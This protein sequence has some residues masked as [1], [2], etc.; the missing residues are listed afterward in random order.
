MDWKR[1]LVVYLLLGILGGLIVWGIVASTTSSTPAPTASA[2]SLTTA[3]IAKKKTVSEPKKELA[4]AC[5]PGQLCCYESTTNWFNCFTGRG[6][7]DVFNLAMLGLVSSGPRTIGPLTLAQTSEP[8]QAPQFTSAGFSAQSVVFDPTQCVWTFTGLTGTL[9]I[10]NFG[11]SDLGMACSGASLSITPTLNLTA[12]VNPDGSMTFTQV[13]L[14]DYVVNELNGPTSWKC[15]LPYIKTLLQ[16]ET[17]IV[18]ELVNALL[19][20]PIQIPASFVPTLLLPTLTPGGC[21][22]KL[23]AQTELDSGVPAARFSFWGACEAGNNDCAGSCACCNTGDDAG[24]GC[25]GQG[26]GCMPEYYQ[27]SLNN[28]SGGSS[29]QCPGFGVPNASYTNTGSPECC[30]NGFLG[31]CTAGHCQCEQ[32]DWDSRHNTQT[33]MA[34]CMGIRANEETYC[35]PEHTVPDSAQCNALV[36]SCPALEVV[37]SGSAAPYNVQPLPLSSSVM[38]AILALWPTI[39]DQVPDEMDYSFSL[40]YPG[41]PEKGKPQSFLPVIGGLANVVAT[42]LQGVSGFVRTLAPPCGYYDA[43]KSTFTLTIQFPRPIEQ[44][45][46]WLQYGRASFAPVLHIVP[47]ISFVGGSS[48]FGSRPVPLIFGN[49]NAD[50]TGG[51]VNKWCSAGGNPQFATL[52]LLVSVSFPVVTRTGT[53]SALWVDMSNPTISTDYEYPVTVDLDDAVMQGDT[54]LYDVTCAGGGLNA[55]S[56]GDAIQGQ[57]MD[58]MQHALTTAIFGPLASALSQQTGFPGVPLE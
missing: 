13:A 36:M 28:W 32:S 56:S 35:A 18:E 10:P 9:V 52:G 37:P 53:A 49:G 48:S 47:G 1:F 45:T 44:Y 2:P 41:P 22:P 23:A 15:P 54:G 5:A 11:F 39:I 17:T 58:V 38:G 50:P 29:A 19:P 6:D 42:S 43:S 12:K 46:M 25:T 21:T 31:I 34:C 20:M 16:N 7:V 40:Q 30:A 27:C 57:L 14:T 33:A 4:S 51:I 24:L 26:R 8:S 55:Y 3:T